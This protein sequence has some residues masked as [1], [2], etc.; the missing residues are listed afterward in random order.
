M[1]DFTQARSALELRGLTG[2]WAQTTVIEDFSLTIGS[3]ECVSIIG[4]N[5]VGK[6]TLL[7]LIVGRARRISGDVLLDGQSIS[8]LQVHDRARAGLRYVPQ[9]REIFPSLTV[10]EHL[11]VAARPGRWHLSSIY[12]LFPSLAKRALS[13]AGRL[14]GGEQQMLA[15]ARALIGNP[16]V[17]VMDEPSEGLA[18]VVIEQLVEVFSMLSADRS[19]TILLV[20]QRVDIALKLSDRCLIMERGKV[21]HDGNSKE[22]MQSSEEIGKMMGFQT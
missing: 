19:L 9:E 20:E 7:E 16:K 17:L 15:T 22:L 12:E 14:S 5:G 11:A 6:S 10:A 1:N 4:R 18:P 2:G 21:I 8:E 3:G 13:L